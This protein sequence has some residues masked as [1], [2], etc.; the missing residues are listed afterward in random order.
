M[1]AVKRILI[2]GTTPLAKELMEMIKSRPYGRYEIVGVVAE[3]AAAAAESFPYPLLGIADD[4]ERIVHQQ[5]PDRIV[6]AMGERRKRL[7][8]RQLVKERIRGRITIED[9]SDFYERLTGK[10]A[11]D[12]LTPS[13]VIFS[14]DFKPAPAALLISRI[15][16][17]MAAIAGLALFAPLY[18]L[19]ALLI[20]RESP[21]GALFVQE[22]VGLGG[23][24]FK[25]PKFRTM[26][27]A[28]EARSEWARDNGDR[29]TRLGR[30]L[31]KYRLDE[32]P[33]F[34]SI[35]RG[36]MN[37]VG[38]R[39][40]PVSNYGLFEMVSRNLPECGEQIPYYSLRALVRP[41]MTGWAQVRYRYANDLDEEMEKLR[42]DLYY[43]KHYSVWLDIR[44]LFETCRIVLL[45][46][47]SGTAEALALHQ[48]Q[49]QAEKAKARNPAA[50]EPAQP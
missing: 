41:G 30:L 29:I 25:M 28:T 9:G 4:L 11:I 39:P 34:I 13:S 44:I 5:R 46:S 42:Y 49:A 40:H 18:Y 35:L 43:I 26:H 27:Q 17:L 2:L 48:A 19:I 10:L 22:R 38:P 8:I 33:Q 16:S 45:G 3:S 24:P 50:G 1:L 23:R 15:I 36:D 32:L 7:P 47:G 12:A 14:R 6:V 31:R 21:G 37:L 20:R